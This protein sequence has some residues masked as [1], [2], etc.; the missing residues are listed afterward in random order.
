MLFLQTFPSKHLARV[1][2]SYTFASAF[3][4]ERDKPNEQKAKFAEQKTKFASVLSWRAIESNERHL[5]PTLTVSSW[6]ESKQKKEFFEK[7]LHKT[8]K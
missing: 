6:Q 3:E 2:K 5:T 8:E 4:N 7:D 1:R